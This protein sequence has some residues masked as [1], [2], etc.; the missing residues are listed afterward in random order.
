MSDNKHQILNLYCDMTPRA[1]MNILPKM[2]YSPK[3]EERL[4]TILKIKLKEM[5]NHG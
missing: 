2:K 5:L 4:K 1:A 3:V